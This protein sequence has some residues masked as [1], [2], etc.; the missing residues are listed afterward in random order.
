M[1][2]AIQPKREVHYLPQR[3]IDG[4]ARTCGAAVL[5]MAYHTLGKPTAIEDI[6]RELSHGLAPNQAVGAYRLAS[7]AIRY[8]LDAVVLRAADPSVALQKVLHSQRIGIVNH[9]LSGTNPAGH[10]S[11]VVD[12]TERE[13]VIHNPATAANQSVSRELW[14]KLWLTT[15]DQSEHTGGVIVAIGDATAAWESEE[16]LCPRCNQVVPL[17]SDLGVSIAEWDPCWECLFCPHCDAS[18]RTGW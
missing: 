2:V 17:A 8:G 5:A 11:I 13:I 10:Y 1:T 14:R 9:Q 7:H 6:W 15:T 3:T 4:S 16:L 18:L 12:E